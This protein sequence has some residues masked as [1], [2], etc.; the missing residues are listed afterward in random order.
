MG[1][2]RS[3]EFDQLVLSHLDMLYAV[4]LKLTRNPSDAQDLTQN[5]LLKALRF[6]DKFKENL[7]HL[8]T[9][10]GLITFGSF[11]HS[12]RNNYKKR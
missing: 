9:S 1:V 6:H 7:N 10:I 12:Y 5:T 2:E 4:A 8:W 3:A 11:F